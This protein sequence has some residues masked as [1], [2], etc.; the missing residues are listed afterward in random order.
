LWIDGKLHVGAAGLDADLAHDE[1]GGVAH[2]LVFAI[3]ERLRGRNGDGVAGVHTH[4]VH[5][6][7]GADDDDVVGEVAHDLQLVFLP[8]ENGFLDE[9]LV[10]G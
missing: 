4:R 7:N 3:G 5:I 8:A 10:D 6:F 9:A 2:G 1:E